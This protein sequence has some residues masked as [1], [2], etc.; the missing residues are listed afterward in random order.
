[1][2]KLNRTEINALAINICNDFRLAKSK[3]QN[4]MNKIA[5]K[6]F[7]KTSL[8]RKIKNIREDESLRD[9][10]NINDYVLMSKI[11]K[12]QSEIKCPSIEVIERAIIIEQITC[13]DIDE[14]IKKVI[15][16]FN[17]K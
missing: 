10:V 16:S 1:M 17:N 7:Y 14:L 2:S 6:N 4:K 15:K 11:Y 3:D 13:K 12:N 8:G 5:D 9:L